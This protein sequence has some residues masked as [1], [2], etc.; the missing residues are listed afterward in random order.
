MGEKSKIEVLIR[1][2]TAI[3]SLPMYLFEVSP[4]VTAPCV[5]FSVS[6]PTVQGASW[7]TE[8][9]LFSFCSLFFPRA[10]LPSMLHSSTWPLSS[11]HC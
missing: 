4:H 8:A 10:H 9:E 7:A 5:S 6:F 11:D 3:I 2:A 1:E